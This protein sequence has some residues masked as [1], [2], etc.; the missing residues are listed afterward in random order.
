MKLNKDNKKINK[1]LYPLMIL[2]TLG[3]LLFGLIFANF[4]QFSGTHTPKI[5]N[6]GAGQGQSD[7]ILSI[8]QDLKAVDLSTLGRELGL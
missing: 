6:F 8:E 3:I 1:F 5:K 2:V 4:F 7:Y